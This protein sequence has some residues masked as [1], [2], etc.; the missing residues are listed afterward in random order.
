MFTKFKSSNTTIFL[1]PNSTNKISLE[2]KEKVDIILSPSLYWV[3]KLSLPV[4]SVREVKKLLPSIFEDTLLEGDYSYGAYK[5]EDEF[6]VFAYEDKKIIDEL[7]KVGISFSNIA[8]IHFAQSEFENLEE[9]IKINDDQSIYIKDEILVIV[10]TAWVKD[11]KELSL[12]DIELSKHTIKLQQYGHIVKNTSLYK[13]GAIVVALIVII[14]SEIFIASSKKDAIEQSKEKLFAKYKLQPTMFQNRST[15]K[16]Y[17][18]IHT[19]QTKLRE[20]ISYFLTLKLKNDQKLTLLSYK[21]KKMTV[22][23]SGV[24]ETNKNNIIKQLDAKKLKYSKSFKNNTMY[25]EV[26]I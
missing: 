18:K 11:A 13:I 21:D 22:K 17:T 8:S 7:T 5:S 1:D 4:K 9:A 2:P 12:E 24:D 26:N 20:Y 19:I 23:I 25:I 3:K 16:K 6:F 14:I 10:P 15:L